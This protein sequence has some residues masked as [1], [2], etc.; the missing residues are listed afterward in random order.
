MIVSPELRHRPHQKIKSEIFSAFRLL[1]LTFFIRLE[2]LLSNAKAL[3][4]LKY[5]V[6]YCL[7][8]RF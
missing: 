5:F 4:M 8:E 3:V 6:K 2:S 1:R 7:F